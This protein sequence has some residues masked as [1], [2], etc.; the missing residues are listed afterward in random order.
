MIYRDLPPIC[1][2][3][4]VIATLCLILFLVISLQAGII[5]PYFAY[6]LPYHST[7]SKL[8]ELVQ[9]L[10]PFNIGAALILINY[11]NCVTLDAGGV[12]L[13]WQPPLRVSTNQTEISRYC[14]TCKAMKPPRAHHCRTCKRCILRMDHHCPWI[15]NCVGQRNYAS[16]IRFLAAVDVTCAGHLILCTLRT[17]DYWWTRQG[18]MW[19]SPSTLTMVLL[20]LN[21]CLCLPTFLLVGSFSIYHFWCLCTNSTTIEGWEKDKVEIMIQKGRIDE[22]SS[23]INLVL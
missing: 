16:F 17:L 7:T 2:Q 5:I 11:Y 14:R 9:L 1:V 23:E 19:R 20:I 12:P 15:A 10:I 3:P 18:G 21:F 13:G 4:R 6:Q 8:K 22:V